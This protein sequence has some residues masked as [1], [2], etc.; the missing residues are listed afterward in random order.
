MLHH[1]ESHGGSNWVSLE[2]EGARRKHGQE[3]SLWLL[4]ERMGRLGLAS[5][6][7]FSRL[8]GVGTISTCLLPGSGG[9]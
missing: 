3:S 1:V 5:L 8:Q 4:W 6:N 9:Y 2:A 7:H